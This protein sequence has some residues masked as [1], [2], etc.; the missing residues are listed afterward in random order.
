MLSH[1]QGGLNVQWALTF[2][3]STRKSVASFFAIGPDYRGTVSGTFL[4]LA[5]KAMTG[6]GMTALF[7]QGSSS[8]FI[9]ALAKHGGL[10]AFVP[11]TN[12]YTHTDDLVQPEFGPNASSLLAGDLASN[13]AVQ[14]ICPGRI[15]DHFTMV[16]DVLPQFLALTAFNSKSGMA[17]KD[18][19]STFQ[20]I[21]LCAKILPNFKSISAALGFGTAVFE[22]LINVVVKGSNEDS[23]AQ[24]EPALRSYAQ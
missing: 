21:K 13:V 16:V 23:H 7:Q 9:Q 4:A 8:N 14:D 6:A 11:T 19:I 3:P 10:T 1:S 5:Q 15:D 22:D 18:D 17:G 2:F 24:E 12:I 20:R